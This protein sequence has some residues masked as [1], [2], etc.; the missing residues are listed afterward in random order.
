M[1]PCHLG[2]LIMILI[3][4]RHDSLSFRFVIAVGLREMYEAAI[5]FMSCIASN[6]VLLVVCRS[7]S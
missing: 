7:N 2:S 5:L 3:L 1:I 4:Y 6:S